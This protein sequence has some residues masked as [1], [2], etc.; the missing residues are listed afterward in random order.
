MANSPANTNRVFAG[1]VQF[2]LGANSFLHPAYLGTNT[3]SWAINV[4]NKGAIIDTRPGFNSLFRLPDGRAQGFVIFTPTGGDPSMVM[5]VSGRIYVSPPPFDTFTRLGN[6][7]FD[8]DVDHIAF[9]EAIQAKDAGKVIDPRAVLI[10]QDGRSRAAFWDGTINR[11]LDPG[12]QE[13]VIGLWMEWVGNRLWVARDRQI[14]ASDIF[15]PLHFIEN[16]YIAGGGSFQ[17]VDGNP[18]TMMAKTADNKNLLAFTLANTSIIK[19]GI[20][21]R[22]SWAITPDFVSILFPGVGSVAGKSLT[23]LDGELWWFSIE[24]ARRFTQ[25]GSSIQTSRNSVASIELERSFKNVSPVLSRVCGFSFGSYLGFSVPSGDVFNRHT[26]VLDT[27]IASQLSSDSPPAWQPVWM[28]T[29]PVEWASAIVNGVNRSFHLSQD[30]CGIRMWEAFKEEREDNGT[31]IYCSVE[32]AGHDFGEPLSFKRFLFTEYHL[33]KVEGNVD[34]FADYRGDWGC[35]KQIMDLFICTKDCFTEVDCN[36]K[37]P[38]LLP[39][40]RFIKTQEAKQASCFS[41][42]GAFSEE[43][44][45]FFQNRLRWFGKMGVRMYRSQA[46]QYQESSTGACA[47]D[48]IA[49]KILACCDPEVDYVSSVHDG[50]GYSTGGDQIICSI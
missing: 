45:T 26:W 41:G 13:T 31:R 14:F 17:A 23:Y 43:I 2:L 22:A 1:G 46:T 9:K 11:H 50:Y 42:E 20:T 37:N 49:C 24:G 32:F 36:D 39:Q 7:Q 48:D 29:R 8:P 25:V 27:S 30:R 12:A 19:A 38:T 6:I 15:D 34:L 47:K 35:W 40:N 3:Y 33:T 28:G 18:I 16:T 44:G 10:M 4:V 21:D 5:A